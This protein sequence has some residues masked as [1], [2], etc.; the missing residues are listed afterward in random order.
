LPFLLQNAE[1]LSKIS[2]IKRYENTEF[3][4]LIVEKTPIAQNKIQFVPQ[5]GNF[6]W[7]GV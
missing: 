7:W 3:T 6:V 2:E 1:N 5:F 4:H